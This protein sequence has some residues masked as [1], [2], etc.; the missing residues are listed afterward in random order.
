MEAK[1]LQQELEVYRDKLEKL[2]LNKGSFLNQE[3]IEYSQKI[4]KIIVELMRQEKTQA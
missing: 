1:K 4:D 2:Y 3:V